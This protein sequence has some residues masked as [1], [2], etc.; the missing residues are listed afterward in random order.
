[1]TSASNPFER[2]EYVERWT[3]PAMLEK[4]VLRELCV[5]GVHVDSCSTDILSLCMQG[6]YF[7]FVKRIAPSFWMDSSVIEDF[8]CEKWKICVVRMTNL[9]SLI[10]VT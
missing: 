10:Q 9:V 6:M 1:M 3:H 5:I 4:P 8:V 2:V 7:R